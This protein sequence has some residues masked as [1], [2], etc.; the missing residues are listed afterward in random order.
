MNSKF[1]L[2]RH[3][4]ATLEV[5]QLFDATLDCRLLHNNFNKPPVVETRVFWGL[6]IGSH[7]ITFLKLHRLT[8]RKTAKNLI[9]TADFKLQN[10][11]KRLLKMLRL[12]LRWSAESNSSIM[13]SYIAPLYGYYLGALLKRTVLS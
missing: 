4:T 5:Y 2:K 11:K 3:L 12:L 13:K 9:L 1:R 7:C 8:K 6:S 10:P